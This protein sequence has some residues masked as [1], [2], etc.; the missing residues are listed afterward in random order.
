MAL[1]LQ[2]STTVTQ[3]GI[4]QIEVFSIHLTLEWS[5]G[6]NVYASVEYFE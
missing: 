4:Y 2:G 6:R 1:T 5:I 3:F